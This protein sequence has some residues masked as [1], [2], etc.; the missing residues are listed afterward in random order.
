MT[1]DNLISLIKSKMNC[2]DDEAVDLICEIHSAEALDTALLWVERFKECFNPN[3]DL[4]NKITLL[5]EIG[6]LILDHKLTPETIRA[7]FKYKFGEDFNYENHGF[8]VGKMII[9]HIKDNAEPTSKR[10]NAILCK[11]I[12][13]DGE[14]ICLE[15]Q[16]DKNMYIISLND[17]E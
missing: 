3:L 7:L 8:F 13:Y 2:G 15:N 5:T 17:F 4:E 14:N 9:P 16:A 12:T 6:E 1:N 10:C 11:I